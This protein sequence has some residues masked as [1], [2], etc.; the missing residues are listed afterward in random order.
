MTDALSSAVIE[1]IHEDI[2]FEAIAANQKTDPDVQT[3]RTALSGLQ[4]EDVPFGS[5]ENT[6]LCNTSTGQPRPVVPEEWRRQVFD[7]IRERFTATY[8]KK[9]HSLQICMAWPQQK[10]G[11]LGHAK[12]PRSSST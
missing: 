10:G 4:L 1:S 8:L 11:G 2:D 12:H 3:Y 9:A 5:K 6:I 7:V